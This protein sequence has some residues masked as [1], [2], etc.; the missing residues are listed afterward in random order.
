MHAQMSP[1][2]TMEAFRW[3]TT[4]SITIALPLFDPPWISEVT[5]SESAIGKKDNFIVAY[6]KTSEFSRRPASEYWASS[7]STFWIAPS[8]LR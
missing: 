8:T 7:S 1:E 2:Q 4:S 6:F 3:R 5:M